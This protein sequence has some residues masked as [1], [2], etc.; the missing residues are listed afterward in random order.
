MRQ[1]RADLVDLG[2]ET[3]RLDAAHG[4][5]SGLTALSSKGGSRTSTMGI[6]FIIVGIALGLGGAVA[7]WQSAE[8]IGIGLVITGVSAVVLGIVVL[9]SRRSSAGPD[10]VAG[11]RSELRDARRVRDETHA[12]IDLLRT[13]IHASALVL[14]L[15]AEPG[16]DDVERCATDIE[17]AERRVQQ[18]VADRDRRG[19]L[20]ARADHLRSQ[21]AD[22]D[23]EVSTLE[24]RV[25]TDHAEWVE[26]TRTRRIPPELGVGAV[27]DLFTG[28]ERARTLHREL[29]AAEVERARLDEASSRW[30]EQASEVSA[31]ADVDESIDPLVTVRMLARRVTEDDEA[32]RALDERVAAVVEI[33]RRREHV[34]EVA[35]TARLALRDVWREMGVDSDEAADVV[36]EQSRQHNIVSAEVET[37]RAEVLAAVGRGPAADDLLAALA[38]GAVEEWEATVRDQTEHLPSLEAGHEAAIREHHDAERD[39]EQLSRTADVADAGLQLESH[40]TELASAVDEWRTL[41]AAR[42]LIADTLA[43]YERERQPA[44]LARAQEWFAH[45]TDDHYETV[46]VADGEIVLVDSAGR[47]LTT[48]DLSRGTSEQLYL[49]L[50]FGLAAEMVAHTPL[51]FVM[52]DVLVNF[53]PERTQRMAEVLASI[54]AEHQVLLFTCQPSTVD[55]LLCAAPSARVIELPRHGGDG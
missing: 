41:T 37:A 28:I 19:D 9:M 50:R 12:R 15:P 10:V 21:I 54:A 39:L 42:T 5:V 14:G 43:R 46:T 7:A 20:E 22:I 11:I 47:R 6:L 38:D 40:R 33:E 32:R 27:N 4:T 24:T 53:D 26:W 8:P 18:R 3:S 16:A 1:L 52:D 2:T 29:A 31:R 48:D 35:S 55:A 17:S 45:I 13:R 49:C 25:A 36:V 23:A 34:A 44:V 30:R 51:P